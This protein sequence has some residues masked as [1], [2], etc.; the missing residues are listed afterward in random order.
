MHN[1][2]QGHSDPKNSMRGHF[3]EDPSRSPRI[4]R[5]IL[6]TKTSVWWPGITRQI[7][8]MVQQCARERPPQRE[9][10]TLSSLPAF[11]WQRVAADLFCLQGSTYLLVVDY[12]SRYPE[13]I[14]LRNT[15][16]ICII[17][18]PKAIS[19]RHGIPETLVSDNGPQYSSHEFVEFSKLWI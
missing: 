12:F 2:W 5:C 1:N 4:Q 14:K 10:L 19:S 16:S 8:E 3:T 18:A 9:P 15:T 17:E 6:R 11:P 13:V 7:T